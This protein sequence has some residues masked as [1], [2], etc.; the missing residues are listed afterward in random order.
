[1]PAT[2]VRVRGTASTTASGCFVKIVFVGAGNMAAALIGGMLQQGLN[3]SEVRVLDVSDQA[4]ARFEAMGIAA[5]A[6]WVPQVNADVVVFAVKPQHMKQAVSAVSAH[7]GSKLV[8]SIAAGIRCVDIARWLAGHDRIV[9]VMPNTPALIGAGVSGLYATG[10]VNA[11]D[12]QMA[13]QILS[14]AGK[15]LWCD[16]EEMLDAVTAVSGS[17]PAYVFYFIEALEQAAK[18]L[19]LDAQAA[20]LLAIETF[21]GAARLAADSPDEPAVLRAKVTSKG[22]TTESAINYMQRQDIKHHIVEA[23][24]MAEQRAREMGESFG[25]E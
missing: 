6:Q 12:R 24:R 20:R 4:R 13:E 23:V 25:S 22:G 19:G 10:G 9:R 3:K 14:A 16:R 8:I 18:T 15:T 21:L 2:V 17:G 7:C 5:H 11:S 1:M